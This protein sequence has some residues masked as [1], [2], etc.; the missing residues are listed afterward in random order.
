MREDCVSTE[1]YPVFE[2]SPDT[3]GSVLT[4]PPAPPSSP[5][6]S[7]P[8]PAP[9]SSPPGDPV[10]LNGM[11]LTFP[12]HP[13]PDGMVLVPVLTPDDSSSLSEHPFRGNSAPVLFPLQGIY[14]GR[15]PLLLPIRCRILGFTRW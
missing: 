9:V 7:L 3:T 12:L 13:L 14:P 6:V 5:T 4:S 11:V 8:P 15:A 1:M 2:V 10:S